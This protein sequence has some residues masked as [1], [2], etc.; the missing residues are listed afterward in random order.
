MHQ[1]RRAK[2]AEFWETHIKKW[3]SVK[4]KPESE[5]C[6]RH[7]LLETQFTYWINRVDTETDCKMDALSLPDTSEK[8]INL[9]IDQPVSA[10]ET[11]R[12]SRL[13]PKRIGTV[14]TVLISPNSA[15]IG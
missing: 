14:S 8:W 7:G 9:S 3:K 13:T 10:N 1:M 2:P 5:Y 15:P 6:K 11:K 12:W 4:N